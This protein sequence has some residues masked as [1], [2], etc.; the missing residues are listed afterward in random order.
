MTVIDAR[1]TPVVD[2][3][4]VGVADVDAGDGMSIGDV[5]AATGLTPD[6]LRYY[7]RNGL[8]LGPV[9]RAMSGHRRYNQGDVGWLI[10]ITKL[11]S[12]GMPIRQ[13]REFADLCRAGEGNE[14][15]RLALLQTHRERVLAQLA[16]VQDN[17]SA[18]EYKIAIYLE[19]TR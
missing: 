18:I 10:L 6:T 2:D 14:A 12:T 11:R 1:P 3:P 9:D 13:V 19:R 7:E 4:L 17:L 15:Q 16:E 8:L 5:A